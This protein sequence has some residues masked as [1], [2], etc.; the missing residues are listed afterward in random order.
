MIK[1][2]LL[3]VSLIASITFFGCAH[4]SNLSKDNLNKAEDKK[5]SKIIVNKS[6][7]N[8]LSKVVKKV[9]KNKINKNINNCE[10]DYKRCNL[11]CDIFA[12]GEVE[13]K[14]IVCKSECKA[15]YD[16]CIMSFSN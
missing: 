15:I 7:K 3:I 16:K 2:N 8:D 4:N 10:I 5:T 1:K 14:K 6:K 13:W 12:F 9:L 11:K